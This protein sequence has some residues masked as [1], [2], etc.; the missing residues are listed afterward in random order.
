MSKK[1]ID[2][3]V[4]PLDY[5]KTRNDSDQY[6]LTAWE[7]T[8][9]ETKKVILAQG[10]KAACYAAQNL[11]DDSLFKNKVIVN[12]LNSEWQPVTRPLAFILKE[13]IEN[14]LITIRPRTKLKSI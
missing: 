7:H 1:Y 10:S 4:Q 14:G 12:S 5:L 13:E 8:D 2:F 9:C 3:Y 6:R 11:L